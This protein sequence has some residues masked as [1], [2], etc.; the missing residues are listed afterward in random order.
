MGAKRYGLKCE[1]FDNLWVYTLLRYDRK[2]QV[3]AF[4]NLLGTIESVRIG[5]VVVVDDERYCG[6][7]LA[8]A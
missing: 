4:Q 7:T 1:T 8:D 3:Q 6:F 2:R 5:K